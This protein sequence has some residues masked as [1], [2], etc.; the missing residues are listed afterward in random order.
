LPAEWI[1]PACGLIDLIYPADRACYYS[2]ELSAPVIFAVSGIA[3]SVRLRFS[4][5]YLIDAMCMICLCAE[6]QVMRCHLFF[7]CFT[8]P[9]FNFWP[10]FM[11][12]SHGEAT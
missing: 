4:D 3:G 12:E 10:E 5:E 2:Q 11:V 8:V 1:Y 6:I 7:Q 9:F